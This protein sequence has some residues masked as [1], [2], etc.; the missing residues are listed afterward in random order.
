MSQFSNY[1]QGQ[2]FEILLVIL[3]GKQTIVEIVM[4]WL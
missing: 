2:I 1:L 3:L 4:G